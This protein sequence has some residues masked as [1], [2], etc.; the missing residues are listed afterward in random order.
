MKHSEQNT[1]SG[2]NIALCWWCYLYKLKYSIEVVVRNQHSPNNAHICVFSNIHQFSNVGLFCKDKIIINRENIF[3]LCQ[4]Q[5]YVP[6]K[7]HSRF[8]L[9][10]LYILWEVQVIIPIGFYT[11][12]WIPDFRFLNNFIWYHNLY[13]WVICCDWCQQVF[14][15]FLSLPCF[16]Y[17]CD[18]FVH[19]VCMFSFCYSVSH[20]IFIITSQLTCQTLL[21]TALPFKA[22]VF[23][24]WKNCDSIFLSAMPFQATHTIDAHG[25]FPCF[26]LHHNQMDHP[27]WH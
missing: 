21:I 6:A 25:I 4:L 27:K 1:F 13:V 12:L 9:Y 14:H 10:V 20:F 17:D 19:F 18:I 16:N 2:W 3:G 26:D 22:T 11:F 15:M 5:S 24:F 7:S 8:G 23:S